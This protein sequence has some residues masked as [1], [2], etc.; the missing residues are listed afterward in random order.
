[1]RPHPPHPPGTATGHETGTSGPI[2]AQNLT[3]LSLVIAEQ[4]K[5]VYN[6]KMDHVTLVTPLSGTVVVQRLT[7]DIACKHT[8][9]DDARFSRSEDISWGV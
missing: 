7:I 5:G 8:K 9:F 4:F 6:F 2:R 3:I 1:M